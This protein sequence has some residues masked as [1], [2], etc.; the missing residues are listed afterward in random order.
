MIGLF[1]N[2]LPLRVKFLLK[3]SSGSG[4]NISRPITLSYGSMNTARG[5]SMNGVKCLDSYPYE[6]ILVFENYP[7]DSTILQSSV[8]IDMRR[9]IG[10]QTK[11]LASAD[12]ELELKFVYDRRRLDGADVADAGAF[13][14]FV[15]KHHF[16]VRDRTT[17]LDKMAD[18]IPKVRP[19]QNAINRSWRKFMWLHVPG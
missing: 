19:L 16:R 13:F 3:K 12:S 1:I 7:V 8:T 5:K 6:S 17:L 11:H 10:A 2:T 14:S 4:S 15:E 18:Q 9:S